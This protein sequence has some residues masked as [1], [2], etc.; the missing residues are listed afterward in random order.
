MRP[1]S[2]SGFVINDEDSVGD[3]AVI[4]VRT[5]RVEFDV[6]AEDLAFDRLILRSV[7]AAARRA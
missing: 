5:L 7:V 1:D 3:A 2:S 6:M 4:A